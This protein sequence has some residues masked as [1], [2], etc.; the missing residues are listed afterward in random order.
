M[1][2]NWNI[3]EQEIKETKR[4]QQ[5]VD[6]SIQ[7]AEHSFESIFDSSHISSSKSK[8][9]SSAQRLT[10]IVLIVALL[11]AVVCV[12]LVQKKYQEEQE[13]KKRIKEKQKRLQELLNKIGASE[14]EDYSSLL[15]RAYEDEELLDRALGGIEFIA[16]F[17]GEIRGL[18]SKKET[19]HDKLLELTRLRI[20]TRLKALKFR[21]RLIGNNLR[22]FLR[23]FRRVPDSEEAIN[24][25]YQFVMN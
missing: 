25:R 9:N 24:M 17:L 19:L 15:R 18:Y 13:R 11:A 8:S 4:A 3:L 5:R 2:D 16:S 21:A 7:E 23:M 6:E 1:I 20:S 10:F 14:F 12:F 22:R